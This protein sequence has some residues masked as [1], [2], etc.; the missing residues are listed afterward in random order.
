M[1]IVIRQSKEEYNS[2][3]GKGNAPPPTREPE[4]VKSRSDL[5][6]A[7]K[8]V[9]ESDE[10]EKS[11]QHEIDQQAYLSKREIK[12]EFKNPAGA[13]AAIQQRP[14]SAAKRPVSARKSNFIN[15]LLKLELILEAKYFESL[16]QRYRIIS[17]LKTLWTQTIRRINFLSSQKIFNGKNMIVLK[18]CLLS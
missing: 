13:S 1:A 18:K 4:A 14:A 2:L 5:E 8:I 16:P 12:Q 15:K 10:I 11:L 3:R 17:F 9:M 6:T 7:A